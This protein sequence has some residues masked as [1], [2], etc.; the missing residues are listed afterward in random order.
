M[1]H[2]CYSTGLAQLCTW[3]TYHFDANLHL[4]LLIG[5]KESDTG[6]AAPSQWDL[7]SDK[8]MMQEEQPLQV[9]H[10]RFLDL[11]SISLYSYLMMYFLGCAMHK[12]NQSKHRGCQVCYKC[13]TN[14]QGMLLALMTAF[15]QLLDCSSHGK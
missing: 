15:P 6:L 10:F 9:L 13:Q 4:Y 3:L 14:C 7:V 11:L 12:N 8:Q 1:L 5:I 2:Y